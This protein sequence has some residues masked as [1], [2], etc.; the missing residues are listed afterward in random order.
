MVENKA[1][2]R[3]NGRE[4]RWSFYFRMFGEDPYMG[5]CHMSREPIEVTVSRVII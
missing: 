5:K 4:Y 1:G 3:Q 2:D